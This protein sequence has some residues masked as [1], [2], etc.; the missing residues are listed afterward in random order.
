M[1]FNKHSIVLLFFMLC[2]PVFSQKYEDI[3]SNN[4][5]SLFLNQ[6]STGIQIGSFNQL[7]ANINHQNL[8]VDQLGNANQFLFLD[9]SHNSSNLSQ[10]QVQMFGHQNSVT[11][12][13]T[14]SISENMTLVQ[15]GNQKNITII[16]R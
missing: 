6:S 1:N 10:L 2:T 14:N 8:K 5:E 4:I 11:I 12:L 15:Q 7:E 13:G 3:N 9:S 16:N